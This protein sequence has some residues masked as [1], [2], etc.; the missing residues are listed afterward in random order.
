MTCVDVQVGV[1]VVWFDA[2][3]SQLGRVAVRQEG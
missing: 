2:W 3:T 1:T